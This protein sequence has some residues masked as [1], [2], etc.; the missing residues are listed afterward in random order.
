MATAEKRNFQNYVLDLIPSC[1]LP[2]NMTFNKYR[3]EN[4]LHAANSMPQ[5]GSKDD[6]CT[7]RNVFQLR[8]LPLGIRHFTQQT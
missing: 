1:Y 8:S 4:K 5:L 6:Y 3:H 7:C 2:K